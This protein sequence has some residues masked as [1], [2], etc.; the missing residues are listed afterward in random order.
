MLNKKIVFATSL[1][2]VAVMIAIS[3][4]RLI[5]AENNIIRINKH[6]RESEYYKIEGENT[7]LQ[8]LNDISKK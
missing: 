6:E 3:Y 2:L 1:A 5:L 7:L 4:V 8:I